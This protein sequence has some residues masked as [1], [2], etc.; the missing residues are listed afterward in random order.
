[1]IDKELQD[2]HDAYAKHQPAGKLYTS[3]EHHGLGIAQCTCGRWFFY[4]TGNSAWEPL[5]GRIMADFIDDYPELW[6]AM[7]AYVTGVRPPGCASWPTWAEIA[8]CIS[9]AVRAM[10]NRAPVA[11]VPS[12][13]QKSKAD[14]AAEQQ[15]HINTMNTPSPY[16]PKEYVDD[17]SIYRGVTITTTD[18]TSKPDPASVLNKLWNS[19]AKDTFGGQL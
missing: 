1:M 12:E 6:D 10:H 13:P 14:M 11:K 19:I 18:S 17:G 15:I 8:A 4:F 16:M 7:Q 2:L 5:F 3:Q 9:P